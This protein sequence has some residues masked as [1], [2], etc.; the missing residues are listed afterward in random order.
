MELGDGG[1]E[2]ERQVILPSTLFVR[3]GRQLP[4]QLV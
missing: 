3:S 1:S 4:M 2:C